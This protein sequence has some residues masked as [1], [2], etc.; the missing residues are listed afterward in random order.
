M[1]LAATV[2]LVVGCRAEDDDSEPAIVPKAVA[3]T[4]QVAPGFVG[5]WATADGS[6]KLDLAKDGAL[7]I[8]TSTPSPKGR[9]ESSYKGSWLV[10]GK[11]LR[12][13]YQDKSG[14]T[15]IEYGAALAGDKL[16]LQQP[17]GRL[18]TVY[19]RE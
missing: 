12:L 1:V 4:G 18:K 13:R 16:T 11:S 7:T 6:S 19:T 5:A 14:E 2:V 10:E 17:G 8:A 9:S 3:F 15:T